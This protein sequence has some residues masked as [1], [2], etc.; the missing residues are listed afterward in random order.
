MPN[1]GPTE[2]IIIVV[3]LI[4]LFG[5]KKLPDAA[6]SLGRSMRIFKSEVKEMSNDDQ[7]QQPQGQIAPPQQP[8]QAYWDQPQNQ[9]QAQPLQQPQNPQ[10][11]PPQQGQPGQNPDYPQQP[12]Q[13]N[14]Q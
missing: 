7:P 9:P 10:Q 14:Q 6:R 2:L 13:P 12:Q 3:V 5:A 4:L 8:Q 1:I 11:Y